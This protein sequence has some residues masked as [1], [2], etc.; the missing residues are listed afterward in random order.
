MSTKTTSSDLG[1]VFTLSRHLHLLIC[2]SV[3][4][5]DLTPLQYEILNELYRAGIA[6][7]RDTLSLLSVVK[8]MPSTLSDSL[9]T[10]VKKEFVGRATK[11]EDGRANTLH[12]TGEGVSHYLRAR[13]QILWLFEARLSPEEQLSYAALTRKLVGKK[14]D[15]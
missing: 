8:V 2:E 1:T 7:G 10:L 11:K 12:I 9:S 15:S 14:V 4:K 13:R 3:R 5:F 6:S